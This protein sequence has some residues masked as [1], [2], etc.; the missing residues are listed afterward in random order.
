VRDGERYD[1]LAP[2]RVLEPGVARTITPPIRKY[3]IADNDRH[4]VHLL[5]QL[6][7]REDTDITLTG[8]LHVTDYDDHFGLNS[9]DGFDLGVDASYRPIQRVELSL[10]YTYDW[11]ELYQRSASSTGTLEWRTRHQDIGHTGGIDVAFAIVPDKLTLSTGFF[12]HRGDGSTDTRGAPVDAVDYPDIHDR[13]WAP[14]ASLSYRWDEHTRFIAGYRYEHYDQ[15]DWQ[16]DGLG[17]TAGTSTVEGQALTTTNNDV[18]LAN[19]TEDYSAN[20]ATLSVVFEF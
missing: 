7:V 20:I 12:Y 17:V 10:F 9:D 1:E 14:T 11:I 16:F 13:L 18:F 6:F 15:E 3:D 5:S 8:N 2:F 4:A 19:G